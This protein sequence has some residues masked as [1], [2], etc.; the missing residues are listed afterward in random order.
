MAIAHKFAIMPL[1]V[2]VGIE[3][4]YLVAI[5]FLGI[6]LA[7]A[8]YSNYTLEFSI[9]RGEFYVKMEAK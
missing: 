1:A 6:T 2:T 4:V 8:I 3:T 9:K 5:L 7:T